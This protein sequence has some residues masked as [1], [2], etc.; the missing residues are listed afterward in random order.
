MQVMVIPLQ[1]K[2]GLI[3][4]AQWDPFI[5]FCNGRCSWNW[6]ISS[7]FVMQL[8]MR[9]ARNPWAQR[10]SQSDTRHLLR[11]RWEGPNVPSVGEGPKHSEHLPPTKTARNKCR[12]INIGL[13]MT[14]ELEN[15]QN[16]PNRRCKLR[17]MVIWIRPCLVTTPNTARGIVVGQQ[18][19]RNGVQDS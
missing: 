17:N 3:K 7:I 10:G 16:F 12:A 6:K 1:E 14:S 13:L 15:A 2:K 9:S 11:H 18:W 5:G 19:P 4:M 8:S